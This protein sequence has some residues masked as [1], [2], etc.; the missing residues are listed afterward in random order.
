MGNGTK[1][2]AQGTRLPEADVEAIYMERTNDELESLAEE[3]FVTSGNA[4]CRVL[5]VKGRPGPAEAG[6][7]DLLSGA[8]GEALR[9]GLARLGWPR[10]VFRTGRLSPGRPG[11]PGR[12]GGSVRPRVRRGARLPRRPQPGPCLGTARA[13]AGRQGRARA[14]PARLG[15]GRLR[16]GSGQP[17][18]EERDVASTSPAP[19]SPLPFVR[20]Q[21]LM[22]C[23]PQALTYI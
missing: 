4:F 1:A 10:D 2:Q 8:D 21:N 14:R 23:V 13:A 15:N 12:G 3:G 17:R 7:G 6:G 22:R 18:R 9:A 20:M 11:R 5:L 19:P 16:G